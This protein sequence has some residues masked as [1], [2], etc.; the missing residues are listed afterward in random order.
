M[1]KKKKRRRSYKR[2]TKRRS[3]GPK[4]KPAGLA[5]GGAMVGL[6]VLGDPVKYLLSKQYDNAQ[7]ALKANL[8]DPQKYKYGLVGLLVTA[9]PKIPVI[10]IIA[11]PADRGL[12]RLTKGKWGL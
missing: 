4:A 9:S 8:T 6:E 11:R 5:A 3:S 12:K 2:R 1:P 7:N 10:G